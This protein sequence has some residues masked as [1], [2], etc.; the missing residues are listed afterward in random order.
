MQIVWVAFAISIVAYFVVARV[1]TPLKVG[2]S[3]RVEKVLAALAAAYAVVSFPVKR[4]LLAQARETGSLGLLRMAMFA[5]LVLCEAGAVTGLAIRIV[6][7]WQYYYV[8]LLLAL[9]GMILNFPKR[10]A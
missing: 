4:W 1:V 6:T 3:A 2:D 7:G 9:A 10:D 8:F 5:P